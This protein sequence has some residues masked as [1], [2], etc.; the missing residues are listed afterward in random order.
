MK[1]RVTMSTEGTIGDL[2]RLLSHKC[3]LSIT[4]VVWFFIFF[5]YPKEISLQM[6]VYK[7][8]Y[9]RTIEYQKDGDHVPS[10]TYTWNIDDLIYMYAAISR[11][12]T[13]TECSFSF[14][15]EILTSAD[16]DDQA[17]VHLTF[18]QRIFKL[19]DFVLPCAYCQA[20]PTPQSAPKFCKNCYRV[21]YCDEW[22]VDCFLSIDSFSFMKDIAKNSMKAIIN[23]SVDF[24]Q[25]I[26]MRISVFHLLFHCLNPK[27]PVKNVF[28]Q[29]RIY[30]KWVWTERSRWD[31]HSISLDEVWIF[32]LNNRNKLNDRFHQ[33]MNWMIMEYWSKMKR[34]IGKWQFDGVEGESR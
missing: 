21:S 4:K 16:C 17:I 5:V 27:S 2:K 12:D 29:I 24:V 15:T 26:I 7:I 14:S 28:E 31:F 13:P 8:P 3:G 25:R 11:E 1:Y 6:L 33:I 23:M 18:F 34:R 19:P 30:A 10:S 32:I 20:P 9:N 22:V